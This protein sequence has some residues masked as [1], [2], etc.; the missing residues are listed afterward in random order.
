[1]QL[2][3]QFPAFVFIRLITGNQLDI[4]IVQVEKAIDLF[5]EETLSS[6]YFINHWKQNHK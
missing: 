2:L 5:V 6:Y 1:M 4:I 3:K